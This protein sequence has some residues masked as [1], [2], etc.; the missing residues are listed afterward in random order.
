MLGQSTPNL[1]RYAHTTCNNDILAGRERQTKSTKVSQCN[2]SSQQKVS[3]NILTTSRSS[4][5][6]IINKIAAQQI[7]TSQL[8]LANKVE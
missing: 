7:W 6:N 1:V 8:N 5:T 2:A 4:E 3:H